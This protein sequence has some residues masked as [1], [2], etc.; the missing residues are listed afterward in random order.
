ME[1]VAADLV[2]N[3][4]CHNAPGIAAIGHDTYFVFPSCEIVAKIEAAVAVP[5]E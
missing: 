3:D 4:M 2:L 5:V 1:L